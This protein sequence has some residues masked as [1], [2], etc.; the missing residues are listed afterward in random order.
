[1]NPTAEGEVSHLPVLD[2]RTIDLALP[3]EVKGLPALERSLSVQVR[4]PRLL[5]GI[6]WVRSL[7]KL[8][9][10]VTTQG[11]RFPTPPGLTPLTESAPEQP[12]PPPK[13]DA[14]EPPET[15]SPSRTRL[16]PT[17]DTVL[18]KD[19]LLY[20]LQPSLENLFA[21]RQLDLPF[22]PYP[23]QTKGIAF[24]MPR[25]PPCWPT[26]WVSERPAIHHRH[27]SPVSRRFHQQAL[28]VCPK[29]LVI[30]WTRELRMWAPDVPYEVVSGDTEA[31][32]A[33]WQVSNCPLKLVNYELLTRDCTL[34]TDEKCHST[35]SF[36]TKPSA[37]RAAS[38]RRRR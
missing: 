36:S 26:K 27:A 24:L 12:Q 38:P 13:P 31:R 34:V 21:G 16:L 30:N 15:P 4:E 9:L 25:N 10:T 35:S 32:R 23:Y 18:F 33:T 29:P 11:S 19:R 7:G 5:N 37:S 28:V 3:L 20:L 22:K 8:T 1:M 17:R 6:S 2:V 14:D